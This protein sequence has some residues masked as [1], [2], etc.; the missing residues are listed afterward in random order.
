MRTAAGLVVFL[1]VTVAPELRL[2]EAH[3]LASRLEEDIRREQPQIADVV[4][5]TEPALE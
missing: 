4:V 3:D 2:S 1:T 5:H